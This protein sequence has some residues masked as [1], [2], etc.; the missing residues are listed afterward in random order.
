M[1]GN[2]DKIF[3]KALKNTK[4]I[5]LVALVLTIVIIMILSAITINTIF[6]ENGLIKQAENA[7]NIAEKE[8]AREQIML[9]LIDVQMQKYEDKFYDENKIKEYIYQRLPECEINEDA[10]EIIYNGYAFELIKTVPELGNYLGEKG[11]LLPAIKNLNIEKTAAMELTITFVPVRTENYSNVQYKILYRV[12]SEDDSEEYE[13]IATI[14]ETTYKFTNLEIGKK[15]DIKVEIVNA[16]NDTIAGEIKG[17]ETKEAITEIFTKEDMIEFRNTVNAGYNYEGKTVYL[18][19][20]IDLQGNEENKWTPIGTSSK[21]FSGVFDGK[22]NTVNN[23]YINASSN[24]QGLFGVNYGTIK[25][26]IVK[27]NVFNTAFQTAG[28]VG[29]NFN[30]VDNCVNYVNVTNNSTTN[31][32]IGGICGTIANGTITNCT[33]Y[34]KISSKYSHVGGICGYISKTDF[35]I[36]NCKNYGNISGYFH[37]GGIIGATDKT[38][39]VANCI[40]DGNIT[41][42]QTSGGGGIVGSYYGDNNN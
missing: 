25:N 27:G 12:H 1:K 16:G 34:G 8:N 21:Y 22:E 15:Y 17:V 2:I 28:I 10:T 18:M 13:E 23:L 11:K 6:G 35:T 31:N 26:V 29:K 32:Q 19:N 39:S 7:K 14:S 3:Q 38:G 9:A 30:L 40:N 37:V 42:I 5:T 36:T 33:N 41:V 4:G 20:D 24:C